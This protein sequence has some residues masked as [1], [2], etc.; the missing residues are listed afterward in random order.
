MKYQHLC[1]QW[2]WNTSTCVGNARGRVRARGGQRRGIRIRD[3]S[4]SSKRKRGVDKAVRE[5]ELEVKWKYE[6]SEPVIPPFIGN[7]GL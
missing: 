1:R 6:D 2:P 5:A 3:E 4:T 7:Q